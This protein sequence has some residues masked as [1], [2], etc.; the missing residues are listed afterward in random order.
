M[1]FTSLL[2]QH[3]FLGP[4]LALRN[5]IKHTST[6]TSASTINTAFNR[7]MEGMRIKVQCNG[8]Q[9]HV[10]INQQHLSIPNTRMQNQISL[11]TNIITISLNMIKLHDS[12]FYWHSNIIIFVL[13]TNVQFKPTPLN[14]GFHRLAAHVRA[15]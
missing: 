8:F 3:T 4:Q 1:A 13:R 2:L 12:K 5:E 11:S 6:Q 14:S 10:K 9:H 15:C 7:K